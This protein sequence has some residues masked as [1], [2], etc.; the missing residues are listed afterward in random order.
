M[1]SGGPVHPTGAVLRMSESQEGLMRGGHDQRLE[2]VCSIHVA[3]D[4]RAHLI[5]SVCWEPERV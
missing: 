2:A 5:S 4:N 1:P 3:A